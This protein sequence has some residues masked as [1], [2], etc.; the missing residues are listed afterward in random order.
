MA[1]TPISSYRFDAETRRNIDFIAK[2]L[3]R[4]LGRKFNRSDAI[5]EATKHFAEK[6]RSKSG[7]PA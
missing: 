4:I 2:S 7:K 1:N 5:R 3:S 6:I